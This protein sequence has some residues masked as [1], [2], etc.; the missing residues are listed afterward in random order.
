VPGQN[1]FD[2]EGQRKDAFFARLGL[3][4]VPSSP[5]L[6]QRMDTHAT[7]WFDLVDRINAAY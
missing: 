5:T 2:A 6:R 7:A 3:R 1:D 4:A